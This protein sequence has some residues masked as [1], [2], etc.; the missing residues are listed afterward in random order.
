MD[1]EDRELA[2]VEEFYDADAHVFT[3]VDG[4]IKREEEGEL[5]KGQLRNFFE[6]C[7]A[8]EPRAELKDKLKFKSYGN[9]AR[10]KVMKDVWGDH[11]G[12]FKDW[13]DKYVDEYEEKTG[14]KL[15]HIAFKDKDEQGNVIATREVKTEGMR[16][17][18]ADLTAYAFGSEGD[19]T[20]EDLDLVTRARLDSGK[21]REEGVKIERFRIKIEGYNKDK[22]FEPAGF[23]PDFPEKAL[24]FIRSWSSI[25]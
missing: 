3:W 9:K 24:N 6:Y 2:K 11:Y 7:G 19:Y 10:S 13:C 16:G 17:F 8:K 23:P 15:P 14:K 20:F 4:Y 12:E 21:A 18:F 5:D 25:R 22:E 1:T